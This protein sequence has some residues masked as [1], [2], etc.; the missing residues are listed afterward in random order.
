MEMKYGF[1]LFSKDASIVSLGKNEKI[2]ISDVWGFWSYVVKKASSNA[3]TEDFLSSLLEQAKHFYVTAESSPTKS[4]PL[5]YYYAFLNFS[6]ILINLANPIGPGK[7]YHHG[8]SES[9]NHR[10]SSST[11]TKQQQKQNIVQVGHELVSMFEPNVAAGA[12]TYNVKELLNHC[13]GVHRAY[14]EIYHQSENFF[15]LDALRLEKEGKSLEFS[16]RLKCQESCVPP[17]RARGYGI[18]TN[19]HGHHVYSCSIQQA[20][21]N[22]TR[23]D[24]ANLSSKIRAQGIWYLI[25]NAG[26]THYLSSSPHLRLSQE[27]IIYLV[28]FYLGSITRYHPYMF[29]KIFSDKEQWLIAEFLAT[30]PKQYLYLATARTLGQSLLKAYSSF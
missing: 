22:T 3:R 24:Y 14:S 12:V 29:D 23:R 16:A 28:M 30:Q 13:V 26:Y 11:V 7:I 2:I 6:K 9:H 5:L 25:S 19:E 15:R 1:P 10:F 17:L 21:Y 4:Q 27:S 20:S 8:L 18:A